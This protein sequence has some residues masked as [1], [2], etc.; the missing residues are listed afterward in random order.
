[1]LRVSLDLEFLF[2][3][4]R[5]LTED[6]QKSWRNLESI[7]LKSSKANKV[8]KNFW[9]RWILSVGVISHW[10]PLSAERLSGVFDSL[11][12]RGEQKLEFRT[13]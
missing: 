4:I 3:L 13:H 10:V 1:M 12:V 7:Y 6:D 8:M 5:A 11:D 9:R 2:G